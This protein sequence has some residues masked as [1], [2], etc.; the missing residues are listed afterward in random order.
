[1][2][3]TRTRR[4]RSDSLITDNSKVSKKDLINKAS[5][6]EKPAAS[7]SGANKGDSNNTKDH[8]KTD[9]DKEKEDK[10]ERPSVQSKDNN[11]ETK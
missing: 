11:K 9:K 4:G 10:T 1:V 2:L 7:S 3:E 5:A 6:K 8:K